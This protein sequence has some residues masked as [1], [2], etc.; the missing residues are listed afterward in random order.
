MFLNM[1][2][3]FYSIDVIDDV[4]HNIIELYLTNGEQL[5]KIDGVKS[6]ILTVTIGVPQGSICL[7]FIIYVND[8]TKASNLFKCIAYADDTTLSTTMEI[9]IREAMINI[10]LASMND[11]TQRRA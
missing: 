11:C 8:I 10:E 4:A 1:W 6:N 3:F 9:V 2:L 5:V 7:L